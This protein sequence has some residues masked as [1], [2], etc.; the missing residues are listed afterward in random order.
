MKIK[1]T[2]PEDQQILELLLKADRKAIDQVYKEVLPAVIQWIRENNGSEEDARDIFQEALIALF[3]KLE[4]GTFS[5]TCR[6]KSF[7]RIV[8]RN[9]W[10]SRLRDRRNHPI[11]PLENCETM[12]LDAGTQNLIDQ[13]EETNLYFKYFDA[14]GEKCKQILQLFFERLSFAEIAKRLDT[15]EQYVRKRKFICKERLVKSIKADP[16]YVELQNAKA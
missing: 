2:H 11:T 10:L 9:L 1:A 6:L 8:C 7:L 4:S 12:D 13:S 5:L 15:S 16:V 3:K 14:L